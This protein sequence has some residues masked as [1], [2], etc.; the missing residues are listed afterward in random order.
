VV[1]RLQDV[2]TALR[3]IA[4]ARAK[5]LEHTPNPPREGLVL[6][7]G[8]GQAPHPRADVVVDKYVTD[9]FERKGA[10]D[11]SKPLIVADAQRLPFADGA[12]RYTLVARPG[13]RDGPGNLRR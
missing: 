10:L 5:E 7:V 12:F 2:R 6:E 8:P 1:G 11:L 4:R 13:A 3:E 9:D